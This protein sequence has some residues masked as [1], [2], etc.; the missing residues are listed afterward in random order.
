MVGVKTADGLLPGNIGPGTGRYVL[1]LAA[2]FLLVLALILCLPFDRYLAAQRAQGTEM[3]HARWIYERIHFD[4]APIDVAIIGSSRVEAGISP[5]L[6]QQTLSQQLGRPVRVASLALVKPG[7]DFHYLLVRDLIRHHPEVKLIVLSDDGFMIE[8]HPMFQEMASPAQIAMAPLVINPSYF[9][10]L[11]AVP[12]RN[13]LNAAQQVRPGWFGVDRVFR[14]AAYAGPDLDRTL[15]YRLPDGHWRNGALVMPAEKLAL[16]AQETMAMRD[17]WRLLHQTF[18]PEAWRNAVEHRNIEAI[19]QLARQHHVTLAFIGLPMFGPR[20]EARNPAYLGRFG[21]DF[22]PVAL[23]ED[24]A[25]YQD[26]N[27]LNHAGA[28]LATRYLSDHVAPLLEKGA[29]P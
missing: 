3:F 28:V 14:P 18:L 22:L 11:F 4:S 23:R 10:N 8:S 29:V 21:P 15:G 12:Y 7:R 17:K 24:P 25:L 19:D 26:D 27:H 6:M 16:R 20:D 9:K 2:G 13:L 5:S 1:G